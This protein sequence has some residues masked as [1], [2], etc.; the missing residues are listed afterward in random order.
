M[1]PPTLYSVGVHWGNSG[2]ASSLNWVD[3]SALPTRQGPISRL[4]LYT[5]IAAETF[6][7]PFSALSNTAYFTA[8]LG[9]FLMPF[10]SG[11][12]IPA[13]TFAVAVFLVILGVASMAFQPR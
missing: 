3:D 7:E 11:D 8:G 9:L 4:Y 5:P 13:P 10:L 1:A 6:H 2:N 12:D